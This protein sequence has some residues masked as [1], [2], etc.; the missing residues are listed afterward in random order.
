MHIAAHL[1]LV[2]KSYFRYRGIDIITLLTK[3]ERI[4][5]KDVTMEK[6]NLS[7]FTYLRT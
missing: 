4:I 3:W 5:W 6:Y 7:K 2:I 1:L